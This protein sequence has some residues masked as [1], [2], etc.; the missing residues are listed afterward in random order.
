MVKQIYFVLLLLICSCWGI[1]SQI[2]TVK[3]RVLDSNSSNAIDGAEV[4]L[5][6]SHFKTKTNSDGRFS[7]PNDHLPRGEQVLEITKVGYTTIR[8]PITIQGGKTIDLDPILL[9]I[10]LSIL[11]SQLG[12]ISLSDE[13]LEDD[14][15]IYQNI[16]GL[17]Q[18]SPD[19]FLN[20]VAYDFSSTFFRPRGIDNSHSKILINGIEMN[21]IYDGRPQWGAWGG[22]NDVQRNRVFTYGIKANDLHFGGISGTTNIIML[23]SHYKKG[24]RYSNAIAN[25]SYQG[26]IMASYNSGSSKKGWSYSASVSR[27]FGERGFKEGTFYN[28]NSFF[29][30]IEKKINNKQS[31]N[32]TT[33]YTPIRKGR[34]SAITK[35]VYQLKGRTYNPN[36]GYQN[37]RVRNSKIS[38]IKEPMIMLNHFLDLSEK[39]SLNTNIAFQSGTIGTT[40]VDY[41]NNRNPFGNYYQRMPSY[42]LRNDDPTP[43]NYY[44][45]YLA[46]QEF[47]NDGQLSWNSIYRGNN[48]TSNNLSTTVI[49]EDI[50]EE[51]QLNG[52]S[53]LMSNLSEHL[54]LNATIS[55]RKLKSKRYAKVKDLLGGMGY[56]D[57]DYFSIS[58]YGMLGDESQS[59]LQNPGRIVREGDHYKYNYQFDA[60]TI[61]GF[62]QSQFSYHKIDFFL[63]L[64]IANTQYQRTGLY[65]NGHFPGRRSL[66]SSEKVGFITY[67]IKGG[68]NFKLNGR[69]FIETNGGYFTEAPSLK[70][71]F[72]NARQNNDLTLGLSNEI[73]RNLDMNYYYRS[74]K[75]KA[76]LT[77]YYTTILDETDL[78]FY[79]TQ[80]ALG[81]EDNNAFVQEVVT[82]IAK[83]SIGGEFGIEAQLLPTLKFKAATSYGQHFYFKNPKLYLSG[84][85]FV[86]GNDILERGI[87]DV[88]LM[89]YRVPTGP[90]KAYQ[91][92]VEYRSSE[93]WWIGIT[94]NYYSE[95]YIDLSYLRRTS[96]FYTDTDG[97]P[98]NDYQEEVAKDLLRQETLG[99]YYLVNVVGGKSWKVKQCIIGFFASINNVLDQEYI[100]GGYENSRK[101][102]Y[103][104][105][106]QERNRDH[107]PLFGNN[108]FFG[109]GI[110]YYLNTYIRF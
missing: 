85:D 13:L 48:N 41:G 42:F 72:P 56:L 54:I 22:L 58:D 63:G 96:D 21:K 20:A 4:Q 11:E 52:N 37:G 19:V 59:D 87:R 103:R 108:Y 94:T 109:N 74:P 73:V 14:D 30:S 17:L 1:Y 79:F 39:A 10:D 27:R 88:Y 91:I 38:E 78:G 76:R 29:T 70:N 64:T 105:L 81:N 86:N 69:H 55:F 68:I 8:I 31:I 36:W 44:Q 2:T 98:F 71:T 61:S 24:G 45:A 32:L 12:V 53:I 15:G 82:G 3:G 18:A 99:D 104:Q 23:A 57:V 50:I 33:I 16:S 46:E 9:D 89:N 97:Q 90:E 65:E 67:G 40:R 102:S 47:M 5:L 77:G 80:N 110:T 7:F 25:R 95:A 62:V 60:N 100:T 43:Y 66:G 92:G 35:E 51:N 28:A 93:F 26:R 75:L 34:S 83:K 107:G 101:S 106:F 49:Q 6:S 84:D